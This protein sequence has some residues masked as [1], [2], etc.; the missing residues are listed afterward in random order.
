[1]VRIAGR[2]V[3]CRYTIS[4]STVPSRIAT[5]MRMVTVA[6]SVAAAIALSPGWV[7][8]SWRQRGTSSRVQA[9]SSNRPA[10]AACGIR[11]SRGPLSATSAISS[12]AENTAASGVFA[13][14]S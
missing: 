11:A 9:T 6:A 4:D 1:M 13:P 2:E 10:M 7:R 5:S 8:I 14:A 12:N 3:R